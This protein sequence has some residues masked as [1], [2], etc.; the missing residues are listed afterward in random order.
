MNFLVYLFRYYG[1]EFHVRYFR[2]IYRFA[3]LLGNQF[4]IIPKF[5]SLFSP[6]F[7][8]PGIGARIQGF[9][10]R[11]IAII[12]GVIFYVAFWLSGFTFY[13]SIFFCF[14]YLITADISLFISV[15][16]LLIL[17][18]FLIYYYRPITEIT[19]FDNYGQ[20][21]DSGDIFQRRLCKLIEYGDYKGALN[22]IFKNKH[23]AEFFARSELPMAEFEKFLCAYDFS[24]VKGNEIIKK[25][26]EINNV[27]KFRHIK[28]EIFLVA[29][30]LYIDTD[31]AFLS[32]YNYDTEILLNNLR[33][34]SYYQRFEPSLWDDAYRLPPAGGVDKDWTVGG[35]SML[36]R[37]GTDYTKLSL[38]GLMPRLVGRE[39][40]K[41]RAIE[42]MRKKTRNNL[43]LIGEPGCGK[44]TFI[45]GIAR[46]VAIGVKIPEL[47]YKRIVALD[48]G[49]LMSGS[50][51]DVRTKITKVIDEINANRNVIL[52]IDEIHALSANTQDP[53]ASDIFAI[54]EPHLTEGQFQFIGAT[55]RRNYNKYVEPNGS[56]ARAF[57]LVEMR[58][59]DKYET[60]EIMVDTVKSMERKLDIKISYLAFYR[61]YSL[62]DKYISNRAFPD[63]A[64]ELIVQTIG[65]FNKSTKLQKIIT[66]A[67]VSNF[68]AKTYNLPVDTLT[69]TETQKLMSIDKILHSRV[70]GQEMAITSVA[71]A[72]KR[73]RV[74]IRDEKKPMASFLFAG[75]TGVGK[76]ETAKAVTDLYFGGSQFMIRVDMSEYLDP[77]SLNR[78]IGD[79]K[80]P[81]VLTSAVKQKPY[82][83][84]LLDEIEKAD[85]LI[86]NL[87]LQ[88]L[89]DARL[90]DGTGETVDFTNSIIIMTTNVGT[91]EII[92]AI[93]ESNSQEQVAKKGMYALKSHYPPEFLNRFNALV[94]FNPLTMD[95]VQ[96]ITKLKIDALAKRLEKQ[97]IYLEFGQ[98]TIEY[99]SQIG[100]SPEWGARPINRAIEDKIETPLADAMI[101]GII[102]SGQHV[103]INTLW[104]SNNEPQTS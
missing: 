5:L 103:N 21:Y 97:H 53:A 27:M 98:D 52:F 22:I 35:S 6:L 68:M 82:A 3:T 49:A 60:L 10:L 54:L 96:K 46:E 83:L 14:G 55:N 104:K 50:V 2:L 19:K 16:L 1:F 101:Q 24:K 80:T 41:H 95:D 12:L 9:V 92:S 17:H 58:S 31:E 44:S 15:I 7:G 65:E 70:I 86:L 29:F 79:A 71:N 61:A 91:R 33:L 77:L 64:V 88:V 59:A 42:I 25:I 38:K 75:P 4:G 40:V 66:D 23:V 72:L 47:R 78:L 43:M 102:K 87:F 90:T 51:G 32:N 94:V 93:N 36:N 73:S 39:D 67:D 76:T 30:I 81:G 89:D 85:K 99:V 69:Q 45:K 37:V 20:Y 56:F 34:I 28:D 8:L 11:F 84:I 62:A 74:G 57:D 26:I 13:L 100:Y 48:I 63:K 18:R